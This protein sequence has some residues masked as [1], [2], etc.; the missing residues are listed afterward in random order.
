ME[1]YDVNNMLRDLHDGPIRGHYFRESTTQKISRDGYYLPALFKDTHA[2]V[3]K[4]QICQHGVGKER[5]ESIPFQLVTIYQPF[6][7]WRID[8]VREINPH[9]SKQCKYILIATGYFT[10]WIEA[11]P[12]TQV[13]EK[14]VI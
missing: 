8:V 6:Q 5:N 14:V 7:Q 3:R 11:I 1:K 10:R 2:H 4:C 9:T 12:L 13:N